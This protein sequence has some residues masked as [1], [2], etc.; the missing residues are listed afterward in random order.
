MSVLGVALKGFQGRRTQ[1]R[2]TSTSTSAW[3][4]L[5]R[6]FLSVVKASTAGYAC[7]LLRGEGAIVAG[8]QL[9]NSSC[10]Q[11][12]VLSAEPVS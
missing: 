6:Q 12:N 11:L 5:T 8:A 2:C 4:R 7:G 1:L 10:R 3:G 9:C